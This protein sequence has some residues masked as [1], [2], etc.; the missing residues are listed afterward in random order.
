MN[1]L[2]VFSPFSASSILFEDNSRRTEV[3]TYVCAKAIRSL[4]IISKRLL[5]LGVEN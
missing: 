4:Y 1:N 3:T 2:L 5:N